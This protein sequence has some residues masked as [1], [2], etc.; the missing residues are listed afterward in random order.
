MKRTISSE[1]LSEKRQIKG[2]YFL[3]IN[4]KYYIGKDVYIE[5][6]RRIKDHMRDLNSKKHYNTY[7]QN[8]FNKHGSL[9]YGYL[10]KGECTLNQLSEKEKYFIEKYD[11]YNNGYNLTLG[12]E[13]GTGMKYTA[14]QLKAKSKRVSGEKNPQSKITDKQFFEIVELLKQ[15][16]TNSEIAALYDLHDRYVSLIR[17]KKRHV[18]LWKKVEDYIP[19]K[20]ESQLFSK[21]KVTEEMFL[22]IV[23]MLKSGST[24]AEIE[25]KHALSAGTGS[26]IRHKKLYKQ[27]WARL[28]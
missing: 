15:N 5:Q 22:D 12:G 19:M 25:R 18:K 2:I 16:K 23:E 24:N 27:W 20:S 28:T 7:L 14:E 3:I 10:W 26:R 9:S 11:S 8:A 1:A 13:G 4:G 21:G 6:N 17:H